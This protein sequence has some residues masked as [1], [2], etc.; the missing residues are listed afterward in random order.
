M[1]RLTSLIHASASTLVGRAQ[2]DTGITLAI[3]VSVGL[4]IRQ[5]PEDSA[6]MLGHTRIFMHTTWHHHIKHIIGCFSKHQQ[7]TPTD[8]P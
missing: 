2:L 1:Q 3:Y 6:A 7:L 4:L 8:C 5:C